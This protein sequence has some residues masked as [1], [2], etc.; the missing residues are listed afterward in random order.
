MSDLDNLPVNDIFNFYQPEQEYI[1]IL[2]IPHS[3]EIVPD[4]FE[5]FLTKDQKARMQDVDF[6][7]NELVDIPRL[8]KNGVAVLVAN[9]HRICVDLNRSEDLCVLNWQR[10]SMGVELV[11]K[12]PDEQQENQLRLRYH[13]PYYTMIKSLI[14]E[15]HRFQNPVSF[16]DLHSMPSNPTKYHLEIN[17]HQAKERPDFCVSDVKGKT[18]SKEF[19]DTVCDNLKKI[20][21]NVTQ[22]D[23]YFGGY[24][25]RHVDANFEYTNN[26]QI[27]IKRGIY[28]DEKNQ[29]LN[30]ELVNKLRPNLTDAL[31][32]TF[33]KFKG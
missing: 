6:R 24:V 8:Q 9:I 32:T 14:E 17:P 33:R 1:G 22:N 28:M 10:N 31:I 18:C 20:S 23:P 5:K 27:E 25:T 4:E 19:I 2:S 16:I 7:V 21:P 11:I 13:T 30:N 26:V 29:K 12:R 3:G 15:L